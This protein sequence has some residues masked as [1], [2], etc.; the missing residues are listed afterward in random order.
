[1]YRGSIWRELLLSIDSTLILF[2]GDGVD[3]DRHE[4]VVDTAQFTAL[5]EE[6]SGAIDVQADLI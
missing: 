3:D 1:L 2:R 6:R 4:A 5:A